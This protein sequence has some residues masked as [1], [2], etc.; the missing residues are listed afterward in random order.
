M[1]LLLT[2]AHAYLLVFSSYKEYNIN[3]RHFLTKMGYLFEVKFFAMIQIV[4]LFL[5]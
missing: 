4:F 3:G 2:R 5:D 1:I